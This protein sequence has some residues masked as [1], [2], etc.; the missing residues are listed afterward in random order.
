MRIYGGAHRAKSLLQAPVWVTVGTQAEGGREAVLNRFSQ[1]LEA[2]PSLCAVKVAGLRA[3]SA[4]GI[5]LAP[6]PLWGRNF[7]LPPRATALP[8]GALCSQPEPTSLLPV[9]L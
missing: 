9:L 1:P 7:T 4:R 5:E 8:A 2:S 3:L 6:A